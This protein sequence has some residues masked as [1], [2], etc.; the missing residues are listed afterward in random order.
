MK[1]KGF[2]LVEL[3]VLM[4]VAIGI[5]GWVW[6]SVKLSSCED[7]KCQVIHSAGLMVPSLSLV[8]VWFDDN[9]PTL[10]ARSR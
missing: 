8:T 1:K 5:G 9:E 7:F 4:V 10:S 6:N 3:M 2:T